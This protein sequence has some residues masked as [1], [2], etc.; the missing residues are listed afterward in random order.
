[1]ALEVRI[2]GPVDRKSAISGNFLLHLELPMIL[3]GVL[4]E[5]MVGC[6]VVRQVG[7]AE[8]VLQEQ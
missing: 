4:M 3:Q 5:A 6:Q 7:I 2:S 1:M 8:L